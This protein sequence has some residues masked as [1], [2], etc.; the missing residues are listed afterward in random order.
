MDIDI[1]SNLFL[2][3]FLINELL[4]VWNSNSMENHD[5]VFDGWLNTPSIKIFIFS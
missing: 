2:Q 5:F 1:Q 4:C 3:T